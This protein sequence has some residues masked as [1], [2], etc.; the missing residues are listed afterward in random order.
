M[1]R[2]AVLLLVSI[3]SSSGWSEESVAV[4]SSEFSFY[5]PVEADFLTLPYDSPGPWEWLTSTPGNLLSFGEA[6]DP[7][8]NYGWIIGIVASSWV[9]IQYDQK[10]IN[11]SQRFASDLGLISDSKTGRETY[12][13]ID[14][15]IGDYELPLVVPRNLNS[16]MYFF[17]D[18]LAHL[19]IIA[20]LA[21]YGFYNED[22]RAISTASQV[23]EAL[24]LTG[25]IVQVIKRS[26]GREAP[27]LATE[28]GGRWQWFPNQTEYNKKVPQFD[29][30]PSGH[31]ATVMATTKVLAD[32][33]PNH[34]YIWPVSTGVMTLLGFAMLNNGV[35][36]AGDYPLGLAI[37]YLSAKVA[38]ERN[39]KK[40]TQLYSVEKS[41][42]SGYGFYPYYQNRSAGLHFNY[43]F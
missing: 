39:R 21:G 6:I 43:W 20:G 7:K 35:H 33:Y 23:V 12:T 19:G 38:V 14:G 2:L 29:A 36:W 27:F 31:L 30:F 42:K 34:R 26:T 28:P 22:K 18:G 37:G 16:T 17:G 41:V 10:I 11:A 5:K 13:L 4:E 3:F 8:E 25:I 40:R 1:I 24:L 9:L 15:R 32:N